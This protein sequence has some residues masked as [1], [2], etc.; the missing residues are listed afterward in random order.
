[1][2]FSTSIPVLLAPSILSTRGT[3]CVMIV[4]L[5]VSWRLVLNP[6]KVFPQIGASFVPSIG[7][8]ISLLAC[9]ILGSMEWEK[10]SESH[11]LVPIDILPLQ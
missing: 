11:G 6:C 7:H 2:I 4:D 9:K 8:F 10:S 1:M 5:G 3:Y